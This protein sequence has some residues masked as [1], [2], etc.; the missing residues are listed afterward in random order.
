MA[1]TVGLLL[2]TF[3]SPATAFI[4]DGTPANHDSVADIL[5]VMADER[6]LRHNLE[7]A[8]TQM[9]TQLQNGK[10]LTVS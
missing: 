2:L 3:F 7:I 6:T 8:V 5:A 4:A 1:L 10:K 9:K